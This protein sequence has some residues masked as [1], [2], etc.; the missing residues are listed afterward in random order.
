MAYLG[1]LR[2][3]PTEEADSVLAMKGW[4]R[5]LSLTSLHNMYA[6]TCSYKQDMFT[7]QTSSSVLV[8]NAEHGC[9]NK[10]AL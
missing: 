10:G 6:L 9:G 2:R 4:L 3:G 1:C 7:N 8:C 5:G